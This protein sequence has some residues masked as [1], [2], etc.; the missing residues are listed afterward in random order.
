MDKKTGGKKIWISAGIGIAAVVVI[1]VI[2]AVSAISQNNKLKATTM[3]LLRRVNIVTL[4]DAN[5]KEKPMTDNM[6]L[7]NGNA[8]KTE[9]DSMVSVGLDEFKVVTVEEQSRAEFYQSGKKLE[10][11]LTEG[12]LFI[13]V[14]K[15]LEDDESFDV[16]TST[17]TAGIRGTTIYVNQNSDGTWTMYLVSGALHVRGRNPE[18]KEEKEADI[19]GGQKVTAITFNDRETDT[20]ILRVEEFTEDEMPLQLI[21]ELVENE[22]ALQRAAEEA[23]FDSD[24][25]LELAGVTMTDEENDDDVTDQE[26]E[27]EIGAETETASDEADEDDDNDDSAIEGEEIIE[28]DPVHEELS[29]EEVVTDEVAEEEEEELTEE[30]SEATEEI[31]DGFILSDYVDYID[32]NG[33]YH[34]KDGTTFD[35]A[36]Y[37][38]MYGEILEQEG[39]VSDEDLLKHYLEYGQSEERFTTQEEYDE[40][41]EEYLR[42]KEAREKEE[43]EAEEQAEQQEEEQQQD[44]PANTTEEELPYIVYLT[45]YVNGVQTSAGDANA[46]RGYQIVSI[47]ES[48]D[49]V[50]RIRITNQDTGEITYRY[51]TPTITVTW[52]INTVCSPLDPQ[53]PDTYSEQRTGT[54]T[55][56]VQDLIENKE[57]MSDTKM[58]E[59]SCTGNDQQPYTNTFS[60]TLHLVAD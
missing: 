44:P 53:Q 46:G 2:I 25:I 47:T 33:V 54:L 8:L 57:N 12:S 58:I 51:D 43:R 3:R 60:T 4:E 22:D 13:D 11:N 20:I 38:Q 9:A 41:T 34:L 18:T 14:S 15:H 50:G 24:R 37:R 26:A 59:V 32:E 45:N 36:F 10:L 39:Y 7:Q 5:G 35:P 19:V 48:Q 17:M 56:D 29:E 55:F 31:V 49:G 21:N 28:G 16:R 23:G 27:T 42:E 6:K 1:G 40:F 30:E 52:V